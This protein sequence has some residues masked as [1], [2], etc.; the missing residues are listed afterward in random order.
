MTGRRTLSDMAECRA[1]RV[2]AVPFW[3]SAPYIAAASLHHVL[4]T[5]TGHASVLGIAVTAAW[6]LQMPILGWGTRRLAPDW[7]RRLPSAKALQNCLC[8]SQ[9][10]AVLL[11]LGVTGYGPSAG[12][13]IP[14]SVL[15]LPASGVAER[16]G[17]AW[18]GLGMLTTMCAAG[19]V[20][21]RG[22]C[23]SDCAAPSR[24]AGPIRLHL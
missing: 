12:A 24:R 11:G 13:W 21:H 5:H 10:A 19:W 23:V 18:A 2:V 3:L 16:V 1:Q 7:V 8:A 9:A 17:L 14:P 6:L 22:D 4:S 20:S 15:P